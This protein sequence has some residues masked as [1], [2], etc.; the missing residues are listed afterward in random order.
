[1]SSAPSPDA[2][3]GGNVISTGVALIIAQAYVFWLNSSR[4]KPYLK[5]AVWVVMS[6][7]VIVF[8]NL[9]VVVVVHSFYVKRIWILSKKNRNLLVILLEGR[10][11]VS[12][13]RI[14]WPKVYLDDGARF[15]CLDGSPGFVDP[16][17]AVVAKTHWLQ[18]TFH[19]VFQFTPWHAQCSEYSQGN[20]PRFS[21]FRTKISG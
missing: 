21:A 5:T 15:K 1:M 18:R 3:L 14:H 13:S 2:I 17:I 19:S 10:D 16:D 6:A 11:M 12:L 7:G 20:G 8:S 4:D 9:A